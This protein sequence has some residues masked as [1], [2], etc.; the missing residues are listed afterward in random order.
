M[1]GREIVAWVAAGVF[2][3]EA[4]WWYV[5]Y[6]RYLR[7][8]REAVDDSARFLLDRMESGTDHW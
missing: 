7:I 2:G 4:L 1:E 8:S 6:R 3:F 5:R